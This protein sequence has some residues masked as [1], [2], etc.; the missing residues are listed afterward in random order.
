ML[1]SFSNVAGFW[2]L[3]GLPLLVVI[4]TLQQRSRS[5][6]VSTLFLLEKLAPESRGGR[7]WDRWR[8]SRVF[9]LQALAVLL[10]TWVLAEPRWVR[11]ESAQTVVLVLDSAVSMEAFREEAVRAAEAKIAGSAGRAG[12]TEWV[13]LT[14]DPRQPPLYRGPERAAAVAALAAWRPRLGTHDYAPALRL[15]RSLGG[16]AGETWLIT[17][18][19]AKVPPDQEAVGVGR[20]LANVGFAG[21]TVTKDA[22]GWTWR[23][24]VK[25]NADVA[26]RR[27]WWFEQAG[28]RSAPQ[29]AELAAGALL[30]IGGRFPDK[31]LEGVLV[32]APDEFTADD[33]LPLVRPLPKQLAVTITLTGEEGAFFQKLFTGVEGV[34][35]GA[36][37]PANLRVARMAD[38]ENPAP[39]AAIFLPP[40][41]AADAE[42]RLQT[43]PVVAERDA[44]VADLNWQGLLGPG[45]AGLKRGPGDDVLLWQA[46]APLA[47]L[48]PGEPAT[49]Q[50]V[51]NLDWTAGNA[52]RLP[53]MVLLLRRFVETVRAA[54]PGF[55]AENFD[56]GARVPLAMR[57][58]TDGDGEFTM[59]FEPADGGAA[60]NRAVTG[61]ELAVLRAPGEAGFF[62]VS[63]GTAQRVRGA[64]QVADARQGDFREAGSFD[65][66]RG[67]GSEA[68][69]ARATRP[70]PFTPVWLVLLGA[71]LVAS[72]WPAGA[73]GGRAA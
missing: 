24:L 2:A 11:G 42:R 54:Q 69:W 20:V 73:R 9:W 32:L 39:G 59:S 34:T 70:D 47:W 17:D 1:P 35:V 38:G 6:V 57:D 19:N 4:H 48:R 22:G 12:R 66:G 44:L 60:T 36:P 53:A 8:T 14:S 63:R 29:V 65:T 5:E 31:A 49:R 56:T 50:L 67:A 10:A 18:S 30:E 37:A 72:W 28:A 62:T 40:A 21:A 25:N 55:Y 64:V 68:A 43:A 71:V 61:A 45:A 46:E 51:L 26:Q 23:A 58:Q 7:T 41:R 13:V 33:R 16:G 52:A 3:L 15:A 27:E